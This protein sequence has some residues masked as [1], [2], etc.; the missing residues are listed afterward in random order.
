M[1]RE[2]QARD[3]LA[4]RKREGNGSIVG[5]PG[6]RTLGALVCGPF[7]CPSFLLR[8]CAFRRR[9]CDNYVTGGQCRAAVGVRRAV[10]QTAPDGAGAASVAP[11]L[12][13]TELPKAVIPRTVIPGQNSALFPCKHCIKNCAELGRTPVE[14]S[15]CR[16]GVN[17][18]CVSGTGLDPNGVQ[19]V[20]TESENFPRV[21]V[22]GLARLFL[23]PRGPE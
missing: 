18:N 6:A 10:G 11:F 21:G 23:L 7:C 12:E 16:W 20:R 1:G 5:L 19:L 13:V 15:R 22:R 9:L 3:S 14:P 17:V 2:G 4:R 8:Q